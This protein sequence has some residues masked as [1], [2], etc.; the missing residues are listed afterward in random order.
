MCMVDRNG[1]L[2]TGAWAFTKLVYTGKPGVRPAIRATQ[3]VAAALITVSLL[4]SAIPSESDTKVNSSSKQQVAVGPTPSVSSEE[5]AQ[6]AANA[7]AAADQEAA[8][9][10]AAEQ[11]AAARAAAAKA[12]AAKAAAAK[13]EAARVEAARVASARAEASKEAAAAQEAE[14]EQA[15]SNCTPEYPDFCIPPAS[16]YNCSDF[17]QKNFT[18]RQPDP[19]GLDRDDDGI[20]CES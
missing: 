5:L 16:D 18:A 10:A 11:A 14:Q 15:S 1:H 7:Q 6:Q 8:A 17:S 4:A 3:G 9:Q 2:R 13:A 12:A 20:A 19:Y